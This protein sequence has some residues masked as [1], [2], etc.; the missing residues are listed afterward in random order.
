MA[1]AMAEWAKAV[2]EQQLR[3]LPE[4]LAHVRGV[5]VA[6]ERAT[7]DLGPDERR[8][9]IAAAWLHDVGY[10]RSIRRVGFHALDGAAF[11]R[12]AGF[13]DVVV[14]LVAYHTGATFEAEERGLTRELV[15][16]PRP[17]GGL[18]DLLT[19]ADMTTG[20]D[21]GTVSA[22]VRTEEILA[23]Y[24]PEDVVHRAVSRS[25]PDLLAAVKRIQLRLAARS[26]GSV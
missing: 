3:E 17:P 16:I 15:K 25:A 13:P 7:V 5:A 9:V 4:R 26:A 8:W 11:V 10:A 6:A 22:C 2:A 21:G 23:R 18:L 14:S 24:A 19:F 1:R 20:P 12:R